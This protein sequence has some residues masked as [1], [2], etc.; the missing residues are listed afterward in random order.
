MACI[1]S[2]VL[3]TTVAS[4]VSDSLGATSPRVCTL[5]LLIL[6]RFSCKNLRCIREIRKLVFGP[7][8][9]ISTTVLSDIMQDDLRQPYILSTTILSDTGMTQVVLH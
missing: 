2:R 8:H 9:G 5:L 3:S 6:A 7:N 1:D 4:Q